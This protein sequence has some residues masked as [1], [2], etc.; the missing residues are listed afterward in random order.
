MG[1]HPMCH[2]EVAVIYE[3][4]AE[5]SREVSKCMPLGTAFCIETTTLRAPH[6]ERSE[7]YSGQKFLRKL[8]RSRARPEAELSDSRTQR[9]GPD[10]EQFRRAAG[11]ADSAFASPQ[12]C[13]DVFAFA[14]FHLLGSNDLDSIR[15]R[16]G[17]LGFVMNLRASAIWKIEPENSEVRSYYRALHDIAK[18][19][20]VS[21]PVVVT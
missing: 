17:G 9:G 2:S 15:R 4:S 10:A 20:D 11:A 16:G 3:F 7:P 1:E 12:S 8:R 6:K 19:T 18:L 5:K 14:A 21:R 13:N